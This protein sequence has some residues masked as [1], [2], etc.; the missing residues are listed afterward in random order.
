MSGFRLPRGGDGID[1]SQ[2]LTFRYNGRTLQGFAGDTL[3]S[4]L[5]ANGVSIVGRGFKY[6]RPRGVIGTGFAETNALVQLG[7]GAA[8][9]PNVPATL[10]PLREGLVASSPTGWPSTRFDLGRLNDRLAAL[11][12]AGFYYKTFIWPN[13]HWFEPFIRRAAGFG[14][15]PALPDPDRYE[16]RE[17]HVDVLVIGGGPAGLAAAE[18]AHA[19][20]AKVLLVEADTRLSG[21]LPPGVEALTRTTALGY[22]DANFV[23]AVEEIDTGALRQRLWKLR[24]AQVVIAT[25]AF[26]RPM[27]FANNDLPGVMLAGAV[28]TYI[29]RYGVAP[30]KAALFATAEDTA[31]AAAFAAQEAGL[32]V[33]AIVDLRP[34]PPLAEQA[35][36]RAIP[37]H[38]GSH[39]RAARGWSRVRGA[40]ID[41]PD[42]A[43]RIG[44]D[45]IAVSGGWSPAVQLFSQ[46]GGRTRHDPAL[47]GFVPDKAAQP[48]HVCGLAAGLRD[49]DEAVAS[50]RTAGHAAARGDAPAPPLPLTGPPAPP[51]P[52]GDNPK[53]VFVDLQTDVTL[54]DLE[55][56]TRENYRS[57]EH[58][59]RYTVWGM[60]VDQGRL[61][62]TNGVAA[63]AQLRGDD[64]AA[65]GTTK[66]RPPFAPVAIAALAADRPNGAL[67]RPWQ[68]LPTHDWHVDRGAV[69]EDFGHL[70]PSHYPLAGESMEAAARREALAV[71]GNVGVMDSSSFGK[72][73]LKGPEAGRFL[74][75]ISL[76]RPSTIP[77]GR[78]RYNLLCDELGVLLDDGVIA[79]LADDHFLLN[80]SSGHAARVRGWIEDWHQCQWPL[81]LVTRDVTEEWAVL[82]VAGPKA[83][84]VVRAAGCALPP[85][86]ADFPHLSVAETSLDGH[87]V[88]I[89]RVSFTGELS[90]EIAIAAPQ[91]GML[92]DRLWEAGQAFGMVPFGLEA[93]DI[94]RIEKGFIHVGTDTD[95]AT[96][97]A[98]IGWGKPGQREG[99]Y[100]GK[101]SLLHPSATKAGRRQLVGL[102]PLERQEPLPVGAHVVGGSPHP[103]QGFVTSSCFSPTLDRAIALGLLADGRQRHGET[104]TVWSE[105]RAFPARVVTPRF[106]D[107]EGARLHV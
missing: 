44:C 89:Q 105:G 65:L 30:G 71:R 106:L 52:P 41:G 3:A 92:A 46:S 67:F 54:A 97:P 53:R 18:A 39:V 88:R 50:A 99:D 77:V 74:D 57:V 31:Y 45:L 47:G 22:Y 100:L 58:V 48:T 59:K 73:E 69:F 60:G 5:L 64:P 40:V 104:V 1:R 19:A 86:S 83:R 17:R 102:E 62:S 12:S 35:R 24:A 27:L 13:W 94:L 33:R 20:G 25:G 90:Y 76:G 81:D 29:A 98:D 84:D 75:L 93:L 9:T 2:P 80:A 28:Q 91:A 95:G 72:I 42:G 43:Q 107:P 15:A 7:E 23:T 36:A 55:Q 26:E 63:L 82:T 79:R 101:R 14:T 85:A 61:S 6:H 37:V 11:L 49:L 87:R 34:A 38:A 66:Y 4:A 70:R 56:A 21:P 8:L 68:H 51:L 16:A 78:A 103:S 32:A 10:V 96:I